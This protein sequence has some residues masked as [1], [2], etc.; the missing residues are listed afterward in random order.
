M[1]RTSAH[2]PSDPVQGSAATPT[3]GRSRCASLLVGA[4]HLVAVTVAR[5]SR[6]RRPRDRGC[7][8]L[9]EIGGNTVRWGESCTS[10]ATQHTSAAR[11][12]SFQMF[13]VARSWPDFSGCLASAMYSCNSGRGSLGSTLFGREA[14]SPASCCQP[15]CPS[16]I[17]SSIASG[18]IVVKWLW[19]TKKGQSL[20]ARDALRSTARAP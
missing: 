10:S 15:R 6:G 4:L 16:Q 13:P 1:S 7:Q 18:I 12:V 17:P 14:H 19:G 9:A 11:V 5:L 3:P 20:Y 2:V 8:P